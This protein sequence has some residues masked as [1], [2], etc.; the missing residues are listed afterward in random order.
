MS[1]TPRTTG[2]RS[3]RDS[4]KDRDHVGLEGLADAKEEENG[5]QTEAKRKQN[6]SK[7]KMEPER[8]KEK[9]GTDGSKHH[10]AQNYK[11]TSV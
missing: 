10:S 5:S 8:E 9:D 6:D 2:R 4:T 1:T 7:I 11:Y 3:I